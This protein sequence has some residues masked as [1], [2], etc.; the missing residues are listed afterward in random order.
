MNLFSQ[1]L[2][3]ISL[4]ELM[5]SLTP[6]AQRSL[7][8]VAK[9][10]DVHYFIVLQ[11]SNGSKKKIIPAGPSLDFRS[12]S[13][14]QGKTIGGMRASAYVTLADEV[15][16]QSSAAASPASATAIQLSEDSD[17]RKLRVELDSLRNMN[18]VLEERFSRAK[19]QLIARN[20]V[21]EQLKEHNSLL[22]ERIAAIDTADATDNSADQSR[23]ADIDTA[24]NELIQRMD[25]YM[26]KEAELEQR[27]E[28]LF[29]R[30]RVLH[31]GSLKNA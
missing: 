31:E 3:K 14:A 25:D 17:L 1:S 16:I 10:S 5:N 11:P 24:E 28:D 4:S 27:E 21:I 18:E 12:P 19:A 30:E 8:E 2:A 29:R 26:T 23:F 6:G 7:A 9:N 20:Q 15:K 22:K 13:D